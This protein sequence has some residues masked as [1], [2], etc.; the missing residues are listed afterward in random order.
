MKTKIQIKSVFGNILFEYEKEHNT[1]KDTLNK[2]VKSDADLRGADLRGA[3]LRGADLYGA[4]LCGADLRGAD[5]YGADLY[6]A[7]LRDANLR[8]ADLRGADLYGADLRGADLY[9]ANLRGAN[10][11]GA[12]NSEIAQAITVI[13]PEGDLIGWK[14]CKDNILA[15]LRIPSEAKRSNATGRKCRA[16]FVDVL[17]L[18]DLNDKR[19]KVEIAVSNHNAET[20]YKVGERVTCD[21][22]EENRFEECAG[23]IHFFITRIEAEHYDF[24]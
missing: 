20:I 2:A 7:D 23:G 5:L 21:I 1:I 15:K 8:G 10:L 11:C 12:K 18:I 24:N 14:K 16:E 3:D 6:G 19:K 17:E 13:A 22:W 4:D 9:G